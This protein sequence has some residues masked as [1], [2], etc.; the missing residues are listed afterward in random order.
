M[1]CGQR[2]HCVEFNPIEITAKL[3]FVISIFLAEFACS[4][5]LA[6]PD[7]IFTIENVEVSLGHPSS[8]MLA[9]EVATNAPRQDAQGYRFSEFRR[10]RN[11]IRVKGLPYFWFMRSYVS[12][13]VLDL[14][15]V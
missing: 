7:H 12:T 11:R 9:G 2:K 8:K 4:N 1:V 6:I 14:F 13:L 3:I 15:V 10:R 5:V